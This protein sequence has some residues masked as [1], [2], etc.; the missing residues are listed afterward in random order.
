LLERVYTLKNK[1]N[2]QGLFYVYK[3][4][5]LNRKA[6]NKDLNK[7][8]GIY[9]WWCQISG[10]FYI[11]S[12]KSFVGKNG[13]LNDY[14]Q[15]SR[16][17]LTDKTKISYDIAKDMIKYPKENWNLIILEALENLDLET[18]KEK[19]QFWMLL[20]PTYNRS[21][22]V[23]SNEGLPLTEEKREA[24]STLIYIYEISSEGKLVPNSEQKIFGIKNLGRIGIETNGSITT[25]NSWDIQAH[26]KSGLP[27]KDKIIFAKTPLTLEEQLN[28]KLSIALVWFAQGM[29][30][31]CM[32]WANQRKR[33]R[34][35]GL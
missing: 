6:I 29:Q 2:K 23:G 30:Q 15:E 13:R 1:Y 8:G 17:N 35:L 32:P 11:G 5:E 21:F 24:L 31:S 27:F 12:A 16:L 14:F 4:V 25:V 28:W 19:E 10:L 18:L 34:G 26:L 7:K 9:I 33:I 3:N 20:I 22:V